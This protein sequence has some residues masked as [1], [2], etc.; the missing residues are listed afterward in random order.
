MV[1]VENGCSSLIFLGDSRVLSCGVTFV[2]NQV[3]F[4]SLIDRKQASSEI[5]K[6]S[7]EAA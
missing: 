6:L 3:L 2:K 1:Q 5:Y 7:L 4:S